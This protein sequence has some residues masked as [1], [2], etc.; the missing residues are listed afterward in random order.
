MGKKIVKGIKKTLVNT[1][2][3]I[4]STVSGNSDEAIS[5]DDDE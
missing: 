1:V 4:V 5:S 2:T 3:T